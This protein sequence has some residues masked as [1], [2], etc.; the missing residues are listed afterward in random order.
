MSHTI[1]DFN[2]IS[3]GFHQDFT[4]ISPR[5][6]IGFHQD[7]IRIS[8]GFHQDF[9]RISLGFCYSVTH[10]CLVLSFSFFLLF[11]YRTDDTYDLRIYLFS[12]LSFSLIFLT[13]IL[14]LIVFRYRSLSFM[15]LSQCHWFLPIAFIHTQTSFRQ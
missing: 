1:I 5:I 9:T 4:R 3:S 13:H 7:F 10:I 2:R 14:L 8:I 11:Y 12:F 15:F 6:S